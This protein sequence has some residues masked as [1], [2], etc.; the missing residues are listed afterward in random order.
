M[1]EI[2]ETNG[3][4]LHEKQSGQAGLHLSAVLEAK[5]QSGESRPEHLPAA[6]KYELSPISQKYQL[7]THTFVAQQM[8]FGNGEKVEYM[9]VHLSW[10]NQLVGLGG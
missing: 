4:N 10:S 7:M 6:H 9:T 2:C 5:V 8:I 3:R 1:K